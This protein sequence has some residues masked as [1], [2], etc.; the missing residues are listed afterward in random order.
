MNPRINEFISLLKEK[1]FFNIYYKNSSKL[2]KLLSKILFFVPDFL[3]R[4]TTTIGN[5]IYFP[6]E[7]SLKD[8]SKMSTLAHEFRHIHDSQLDKLYN[9]KYLFPQIFSIL[10]FALS[11]ISFWFLIP[12]FAL[13]APLPAYWRMNIELNGYTTSLFVLNLKLKEKNVHIEER[14]DNLLDAVI[15]IDKNF[16]GSSYYFMWIP[17]VKKELANRAYEILEEKIER[18]DSFYLFIKDCFNQSEA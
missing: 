5:N 1:Y 14:L 17:G 4:F 18:E 9:L 13:L 11:F 16:T 10:F 7:D 8:E 3:T 2:M 15:E 6:S 12:A